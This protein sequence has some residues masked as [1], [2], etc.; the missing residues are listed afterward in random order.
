[1]RTLRII[2]IATSLAALSL[3]VPAWLCAAM[4]H[5]ARSAETSVRVMNDNSESIFVVLLD[6]Q[7]QYPLGTVDGHSMQT[8]AVPVEAVGR[9]NI[10]IVATSFSDRNGVESLPMTLDP[11]QQ[12]DVLAEM[13]VI[14]SEILAP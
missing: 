5:P 12:V 6:G 10:R 14:P 13:P 3:A 11:G 2:S 4:P 8:L 7:A 1:M 9:P